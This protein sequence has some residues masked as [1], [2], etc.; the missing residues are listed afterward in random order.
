MFTLKLRAGFLTL[1]T[2]VPI[3]IANKGLFRKLSI[4]A[5]YRNVSFVWFLFSLLPSGE[6]ELDKIEEV[7]L[8]SFVVLIVRFGKSLS[9][10][11]FPVTCY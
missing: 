1:R 11:T 8:L 2:D 9:Q 4:L 3:N 10:R 5:Y 7:M 6:L